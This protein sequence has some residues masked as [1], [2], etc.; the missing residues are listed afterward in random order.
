MLVHLAWCLVLACF[1]SG[2]SA[3]AKFIDKSTITPSPDLLQPWP[4]T[5]SGKFELVTPVVIGG[6]TFSASPKSIDTPTPWISLKNDGTPKTIVPKVKGGETKNPWP[7]YGTYFATPMTMTYDLSTLI[8]GHTGEK[9]LE[10]INYVPEDDTN[11]GLTPLLRCTPDRYFDRRGIKHGSAPFCTPQQN[12]H[13]MAHQI[14]WV[15]WYTTYFNDTDM[16]RLHL[17]YVEESHH[18]DVTKRSRGHAFWTTDWM[19]NS[20]MYPLLVQE[21][22]L[23]GEYEQLAVL[24]IQSESDDNE[25]FDVLQGT[26]IKLRGKYH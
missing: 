17:A 10:A 26:I 2:L 4:R 3:S 21:D 5:V 22:W 19:D 16:I 20:G 14:H 12:S 25:V 18:R 7:D 13:I 8:A 15:T 6:I 23:S 11:R 1:L 9:Y 24:A